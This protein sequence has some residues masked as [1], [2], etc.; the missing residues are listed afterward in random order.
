MTYS[1]D[2]REK[3]LQFIEKGGSIVEGARLFGVSKPTIYSWIKLKEHQ[4]SLEAKI[5]KRPWRKLDPEA[6]MVLL[7]E[8]PS[9]TMKEYGEHFGMSQPSISNAFARLRITR[10][11]RLYGT[12]REMK[13][14][15]RYFWSR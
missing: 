1:T 13:R 2:L 9:W 11:K 10:K 12:K 7:K 8:H 15:V 14:G 3:V 6:L 5:P 4:G